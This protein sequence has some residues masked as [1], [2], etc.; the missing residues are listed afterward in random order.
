MSWCLSPP[1]GKELQVPAP[2]PAGT[3]RGIP[4]GGKPS[5]NPDSQSAGPSFP[6]LFLFEGAGGDPQHGGRVSEVTRL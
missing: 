6:F 2:P 3:R 1:R 4:P 5:L